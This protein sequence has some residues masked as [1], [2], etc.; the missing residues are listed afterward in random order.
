[1]GLS[2]MGTFMQAFVWPR[3]LYPFLSISHFPNK[4]D[5]MWQ[6]EDY[7]TRY[8]KYTWTPSVV[9]FEGQMFEP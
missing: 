7:S 3:L 2:L 9:H 8:Y 1:M 5:A 4:T 6:L